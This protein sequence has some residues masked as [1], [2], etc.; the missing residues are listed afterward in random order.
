MSGAVIYMVGFCV[1]FAALCAM[2][3]VS[4]CRGARR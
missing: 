4:Q 3:M 1:V 2:D